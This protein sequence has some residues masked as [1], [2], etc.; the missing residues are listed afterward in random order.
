MTS[1]EAKILQKY[2]AFNTTEKKIADY[3]L[4]NIEQL[5]HMPIADLACASTASQ[6]AW[7]RFAKRLGFNGLKDLKKRLFDEYN[8]NS[9]TPETEFTDIK[10]YQNIEALANAIRSSSL[11]AIED[12]YSALDFSVLDKIVHQILSADTVRLFGVGASA[13]VAEDFASKLL[14]IGKNVCFHY[15][16]HIQLSYAANAGPKDIAFLISYTGTT[17]EVLEFAEIL[18]STQTPTVS[19]TKVESNP[20]SRQ[21]DFQLFAKSSEINYR[22]GA[23]SSR[24]AQLF[25]IDILYTALANQDYDRVISRLQKSHISCGRHRVPAHRNPSSK[26]R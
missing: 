21:T 19:L 5:F 7:V 11:Q 23:M 22:S 20:L 12:T 4:K 18:K 10:D 15:D 8:A 16:T 13:N 25:V 17:M 9:N 3:I 24:Q 6:T 14:R 26:K 2:D 1:I